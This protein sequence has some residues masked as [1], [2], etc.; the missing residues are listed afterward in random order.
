ML[1]FLAILLAIAAALQVWSLNHALDGVSHAHFADPPVAEPGE[2]FDLVT[3]M[4][5]SSR[6]FIPFV[7]ISEDLPAEL[8][9]DAPGLALREGATG[10]L[11][12][13]S[14]VYLLPRQRWTRRL[15]AALPARGRYLLRG[16]T[17]QGGDFL[18]LGENTHYFSQTAEV[19][20]LPRRWEGE[21]PLRTL[22]GFLGDVS[23]NR[24]ILEDPV[25]TL[26]FRD[27]TGREPQKSISWAQSAR[28]GRLMVKNYDHTLE[29]SVSVLMNVDGPQGPG[30]A[31]KAEGCF[32]LARSVCEELERRH[33]AYRFLTNARAV[34][35]F[36][37]W[38]RVGE[39]MGAGHLASILEG[40]GRSSYESAGPFDRI[41]EQAA[42]IA[43]PGR[44]HVLLSPGLTPE[45]RAGAAALRARTGG[46]VLV[47]T[48]DEELR[49]S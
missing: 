14:T 12:L 28:L 43:E 34:G 16:A 38:S 33:V 3:R 48:P 44:C 6:R 9:L 40:L 45:L 13:D 39:G 20:V 4:T 32:S 29:L 47:L 37:L 21:T 2:P 22:G 18:G 25:L 36:S 49:L 11:R 8:T 15:P 7:R 17:L 46:A 23:V 26:G 35:A 10:G 1:L 30:Y 19:V 27:Y 42:R 24:F 31:E 5:N 41:W